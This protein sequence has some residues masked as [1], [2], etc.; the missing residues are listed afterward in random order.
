MKQWQNILIKT[1]WSIAGAALIFL[2]VIAWKAKVSKKV[3]Q[4][5][6]ELVGETTKALFMDENEITQILKD[7]GITKGTIVESINL[8]SIEQELEKIRWIKNAELFINNQQLLEVKIQQRIPIA[9]VFTSAGSSFYIDDQGRR[10]PLKQLTVL[11]L[12][13]FTGFPTDQ[14]KL[15]APDSLLLNDLLLFSNTIK[16]DSFFTAQIAQVNIGPNGDFQM[17]PSLGDHTVLIGSVD[18]LA[19]KLNRLYTF[20]KKV[21][22]Q[23]GINAYQVLDCRFDGQ[24]VALKKGLEPIQ[25]APGMMPFQN[26]VLANTENVILNTDTLKK[27]APIAIKKEVKL[28]E[29]KVAKKPAVKVVANKKSTPKKI[30]QQIKKKDNKQNNKS[31]INKKKSA[32]A[33]MPTKTTSKN[34]NNN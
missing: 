6:V 18:N 10:L 5:Q 11:R 14:D 23:S 19:D 31:L 28:E 33:L 16:T 15:S 20:Y 2:F 22:V 3:S 12:P 21:W 7:Q 24:I 8:T 29:N 17:V 1:L 27:V 26:S 34:N 9:R 25:Y 32:K 13:V 4:I 30:N